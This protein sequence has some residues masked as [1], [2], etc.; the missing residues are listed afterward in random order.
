LDRAANFIGS[1][2]SDLDLWSEQE[3]DA[4]QKEVD[5]TIEGEPQA[6][7]EQFQKRKNQLFQQL[8]EERIRRLRGE[9]LRKKKIDFDQALNLFNEA[10][11]IEPI[12]PTE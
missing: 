6:G 11:P 2:P 7:E 3:I 10:L 5:A 9:R 12:A 1:R 8:K 4:V